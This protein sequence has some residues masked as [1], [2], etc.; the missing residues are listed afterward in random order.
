MIKYFNTEAEYAASVKS[1]FE[2]E[3]ALVGESNAV[4]YDGRNVVVGARSATTG[5]IVVLDGNS[6]MHFVSPETFSSSSFMSNYTVV[7]VVAVGVDHKDYRGKLVV[8][9]KA[10]ASRKWSEIYSFKLTGY[11]LDGTDRTGILSIRTA[12]AWGAAK[13][14]SVSYNAESA[15]DLVAQLN[16]YFSADEQYTPV[17]GSAMAN[18]FKTQSWVASAD[19]E[20]EIT[21][22][23]LFSAS[24]QASNAGKSGFALTANLLPG[25]TPSSAMLRRNG[26]RSGEGSIGSWYRALAY[27]R[28]DNGTSP[29]QGG[30]TV[31]QGSNVKQ[32]YPI[33]LPTW[34]GTSTQNPGDFCAGLRAIYG[35]GEAGWLKFMETCLPLRPTNYGP[36]GDK[37]TYGDGKRNTYHMAGVKFTKQDGTEIVAFPAADYSASVVYNHKLLR[38][39]EW[40][41]PDVDTLS[42][43]VEGLLYGTSSSRNAD[44]VNAGL[45]AIGGSALSNGLSFWSASRS[46]ALSAWCSYGVYGYLSYG[47]MNGSNIAVPVVLFDVS[48]A[49]S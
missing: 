15:E 47:G 30:R 39:G 4:H 19:D 16:A 43:I 1:E 42:S 18:P 33:N 49:N 23:F 10:N 17:G 7:G 26:Y 3:V 22:T 25:I 11:T 46:G 8:V 9:H 31:D 36:M 38:K 40:Q 32:Q 29:Y 28:N 2:S 44:L 14:F 24:Q 20:G 35:E 27:Y 48:E 45:A 37:A 34:L 5:S 12:D 6:A 41:L 21:L 13:D